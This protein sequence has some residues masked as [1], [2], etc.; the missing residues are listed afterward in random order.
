MLASPAE[1][2]FSSK[3]WIFEIKWDGI[4]AISYINKELRI[5]SR[6]NIELV[7]NFP[8]LRELETLIDNA[9]LDGEIVVM[10]EG[11]PDF[12]TLIERSNATDTRDIE[13]M[14]QKYSATYVVFDILEK[15]G[16]PLI[17]LPLM[18]RK[19]FLKRFLKEGRHVTISMFVEDEGEAYY[20][21]AVRKGIEGI[22]A[23]KKSSVYEPGIRSHTWLKIKKL[24]SCDCIIFGFTKGTGFREQ[25]FGALILGLYDESKSIFVG[26]VG[27]GFTDR[28]QERLVEAFKLLV[29][30]EET[31][32]GVDVPEK[33]T[34]LKP[35]L[36]CQVIYQSVTK[37][38]KLRMARYRGLRLDKTATECK[39]DQIRHGDLQEYASKRNF[40]VTPEPQG[41]EPK[42][43]NKTFVVQE[44]HARRLHYDLRLERHGVL[45]S[46]AVPKGMPD[47]PSQKRLAVATEDHPID[48]ASFE[49]TIPQGEYGAG[50]VKIWDKGEFELKVWTEDK[51]E[52][53]LKGQRLKGKYVLAKFKEATGK[54]WL[55]IKAKD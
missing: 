46:W 5:K 17:D 25:T 3:D 44:H 50:T 53:T 24:Q 30:E 40:A 54:N 47:Q 4:R 11:K 20:E 16:K 31:L 27:T 48:Y 39:I 45:K 8:E 34:W 43:E 49:G 32:E 7:H 35:Q 10:R 12:Q 38:G 29:V 42:V 33:V 21:L 28:D 1:T 41:V 13:Y 55:I 2:P 52:F 18:E 22:M 19:N 15:D 14:R 6:N 9:V 51:I 26:K 23:K 37:H 36:V